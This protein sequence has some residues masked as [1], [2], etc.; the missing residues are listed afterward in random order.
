MAFYCLSFIQQ[1][2]SLE[3]YAELVLCMLLMKQVLRRSLTSGRRLIDEQIKRY[4]R[5][6]SRREQ[7]SKARY[8][9]KA[10]ALP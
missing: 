9:H 1:I 10:F 4:F 7:P 5:L 2:E 8:F 6:F 3:F